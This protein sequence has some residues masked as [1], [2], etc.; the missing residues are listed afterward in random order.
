VILRPLDPSPVFEVSLITPA[1]PRMSA[2][3]AALVDSIG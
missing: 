1:G 3:T 2:A